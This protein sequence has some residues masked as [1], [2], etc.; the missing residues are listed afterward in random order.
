MLGSRGQIIFF[1]RWQPG[2]IE[3]A[4]EDLQGLGAFLA[5]HQR[6]GLLEWEYPMSFDRNLLSFL[7]RNSYL[8]STGLPSLTCH[9]SFSD[10]MTA[11]RSSMDYWMHEFL[12]QSLLE[13]FNAPKCWKL[14]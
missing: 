9:D 1:P 14:S 4:E 8:F 12:R 3:W 10:Y 5:D 11:L 2:R 6:T 7:H 13:L